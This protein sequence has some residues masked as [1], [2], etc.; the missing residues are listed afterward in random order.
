MFSSTTIASSTTRPMASTRPSR[1]N[2]LIEKPATYITKKAP[3]SD[4]GIATTGINV[5]RQS[6]RKEKITRI[7]SPKA[8]KIVCCTSRIDRLMYFVVSKPIATSMSAGRSFLICGMRRWNSSAISILLAPGCG[9]TT[10]ATI[11][12]PSR[13][14]T[15][16]RLLAPSSAV[17]ISRNRTIRPPSDFKIRFS[18]ASGVLRRPMVRTGSST[19]RPSI[20]PAGSSTLPR[21][22]ASRTSS[23]VSS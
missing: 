11:G 22:M 9:R 14:S 6:R 17:P 2:T 10:T 8:R 15:V 7:T 20:R 12:T 19:S 21:S 13:F 4:T 1:V 3:V 5:V 18:N 16:R 23:G